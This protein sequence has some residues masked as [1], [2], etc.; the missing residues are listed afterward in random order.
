[1]ATAKEKRDLLAKWS[2]HFPLHQSW[3]DQFLVRRNGP[4]LSGICL[5]LCRDPKTYKPTLF[6]HNLIVP[7]PVITLAYAAP[8]LSRGVNKP[9]RY[10]AFSEAD[11][12]EFKCQ[13]TLS[14]EELTFDK[15][16]NHVVAAR[17]GKLGTQAVYLPH[18]LRDVIVVGS[19]LGDASY[20]LSVLDHCAEEIEHEPGLNLHI[21]G[22]IG[23][24]KESVRD[25][26]GLNYEA[27]I[28]KECERHGL[29]PLPDLGM[30]YRR[31][32]NFWE[33]LS[34]KLA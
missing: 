18:A 17:A 5:D 33:L 11:V 30:T 26:I 1:M 32:E 12:K 31:P 3:K 4:L 34:R 22:S 20:Y 9:L 27:A 16:F 14:C 28:K 21:I 19:F 10:A 13:L 7:S 6:F 25:L 8:L 23:Q 24:W 29:A 15:F 2:A